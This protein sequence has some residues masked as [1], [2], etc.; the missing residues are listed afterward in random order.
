ML[1]DIDGNDFCFHICVELTIIL[2][3]NGE[4]ALLDTVF[5]HYREA[6]L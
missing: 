6:F 3:I 1:N 5:L 2:I 4:P